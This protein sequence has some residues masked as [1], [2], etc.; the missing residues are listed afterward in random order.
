MLVWIL[1]LVPSALVGFL[2]A[3]FIDKKW[4]IYVA[5]LVPWLGL[6]AALLYT[7]FYMEYQG[8]GASMWIIAQLFGG[9]VAALTGVVAYK[10]VNSIKQN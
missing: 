4:A 10:V 9:T 8:G 1:L 3:I 6:L 2:C 5:G 7:E